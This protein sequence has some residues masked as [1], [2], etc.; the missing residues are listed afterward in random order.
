M[1]GNSRR[2]LRAVQMMRLENVCRW[3]SDVLGN[4][5]KRLRNIR[6][7]LRNIRERLG[8]VSLGKM[9]VNIWKRLGSV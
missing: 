1:T 8:N 9:L 2:R 4:I 7:R 6:R 5:R 3:L